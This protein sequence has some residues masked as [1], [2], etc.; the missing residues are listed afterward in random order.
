MGAL[1]NEIIKN[2]GMNQKAGDLLSTWMT[3]NDPTTAIAGSVHAH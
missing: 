1:T 3:N 2:S